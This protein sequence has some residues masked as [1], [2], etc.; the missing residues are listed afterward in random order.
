MVTLN[1]WKA[2]ADIGVKKGSR[3]TAKILI[4]ISEDIIDKMNFGILDKEDED[5]E[6]NHG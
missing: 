2:G 4:D 6:V 1:A 5:K 3:R